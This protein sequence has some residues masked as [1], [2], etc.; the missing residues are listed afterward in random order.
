[1]KTTIDAGGRVVI[2]KTI[3]ETAGLRSGQEMA[4]RYADGRIEIEPAP[5]AVRLRKKG[6]LVVA[7]AADRGSLTVESVRRTRGEL[8]QRRAL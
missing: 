1:M 3:R 8:R 4:V 2:P 6:R 7:V 5:A